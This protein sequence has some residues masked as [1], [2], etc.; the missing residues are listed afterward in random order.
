MFYNCVLSVIQLQMYSAIYTNVY[1]LL[2]KELKITK[3]SF[4]IKILT[5]HTFVKKRIPWNKY[6][7]FKIA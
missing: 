7:I 2:L 5:F 4:C 6:L 1:S 3:Y